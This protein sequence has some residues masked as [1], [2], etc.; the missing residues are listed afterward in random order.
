MS[1][2]ASHRR[3][4]GEV[5]PFPSEASISPAPI[6]P[7]SI[8][9]APIPPRP[10]SPVPICPA[11][12]SSAPISPVQHKLRDMFALQSRSSVT[13]FLHNKCPWQPW[14][15]RGP[16]ANLSSANLPSANL[17][18][19]NLPIANLPSASLPSANVPNA[20][21][22]ENVA[23]RQ[24]RSSVQTGRILFYLPPISRALVH[25]SG[26]LRVSRLR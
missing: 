9:P 17:P 16:S 8:S 19:A 21:A 22:F 15:C 13:G 7:A 14:A 3:E 23:T 26:A 4:F 1:C 5:T 2:R 20:A 18:S 12:V 25:M 24:H 10:I 6:S 11:P